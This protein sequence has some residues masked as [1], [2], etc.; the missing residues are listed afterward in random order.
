MSPG[1]LLTEVGKE[2]GDGGALFVGK[3]DFRDGLPPGRMPGAQIRDVVLDFGTAVLQEFLKR[4]VGD[5]L[6][7]RSGRVKEPV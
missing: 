4:A 7:D 1:P 5:D 3:N 6:G 2:C